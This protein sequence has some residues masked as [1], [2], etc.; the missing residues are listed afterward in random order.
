MGNPRHEGAKRE[1][2]TRELIRTPLNELPDATGIPNAE[3]KRAA[4][5]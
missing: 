4:L 3:S 1:D 5:V 2:V